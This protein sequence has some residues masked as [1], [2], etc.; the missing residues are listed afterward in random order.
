MVSRFGNIHAFYQSLELT[1]HLPE[2]I[3]C[4]EDLELASGERFQ[5]AEGF[6]Y[7]LRQGQVTLAVDDE[8]NL[9]G[10]VIENMPLGLLGT[11]VRRP[12]SS[13][14]ARKIVALAKLPP[15]ILNVFFIIRRRST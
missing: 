5:P 9:L 6:I 1:S 13:T 10:I 3:A 11:I 14:A 2:V 7:F 12:D 4:G 8:Q 15:A